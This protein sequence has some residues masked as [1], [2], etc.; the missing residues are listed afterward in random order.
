MRLDK[1]LCK[2]TELTRDQARAVLAAGKVCVNGEI[3]S[4]ES[5][6]VHENNNILYDEQRLVTRPSRYIMMHKSSGTVCSNV[7][8]VY[9]SLLRAITIKK[10]SELHI[11]G[12]LDV[13]TTGLVLVTD[14]GRW[15][16]D[17]IRPQKRCPKVYRVS[18]RDSV[19]DDTASRFKVGILLQGEEQVTLPAELVC[20]SPRQVLLTITEGRYHQVKR[21]F[22][23][24]GNRVVGLHREKVGELSLDVAV[25]EWRYLTE[26]EVATFK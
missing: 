5:M 17:I 3:I 1:F 25:G 13:D 21:M 8:G 6:Q 20:V 19:S 12:R 11:A 18:L 7:D 23:A 15:S 14:D 22:A 9:P 26:E 16:F 10:A 24:V 4:D 2:S